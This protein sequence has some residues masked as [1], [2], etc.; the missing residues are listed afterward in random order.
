M[1][2]GGRD[3]VVTGGSSGIGA[4]TV[5]ALAR[6]GC[7]VVA[8][9]R[10]RERLAAVARRTGARTVVADLATPAGLAVAVD[11]A[12]R[13]DLLVCAAGRGWAGAF[14][15]MPA[16]ELAALV[17]L[18]LVV[19][20]RLARAA[21]PHMLAR[22]RGHL[23]F[24]SSIAAVGIRGEAAYAA[25]KAGL[26]AFAAA[27]RS[28]VA[29][30]G[31]GVTAMLPGVVDTPFFTRRGRGYERRFPSPVP[32][33]AVARQLLRAVERDRAEVFVPRWLTIA[34][35]VHGAAPGVFHR[36]AGRFA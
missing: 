25:S 19:P 10:D 31:I 11:A 30:G 9:G 36:L 13:A 22:G 21:L 33:H 24:V 7:R 3:A 6:A 29:A 27:V 4:E 5:A 1:L 23:V 32:A 8:L 28:E 12:A 34:A 15:A 14:D 35:R 26:R 2:V 16:D 17:A 20:L 18:D